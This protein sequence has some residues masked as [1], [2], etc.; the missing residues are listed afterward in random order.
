MFDSIQE[1]LSNEKKGGSNR[2]RH[3][4][5]LQP[6][7][8]YTVRLI[9]NVKSPKDTFFHYHHHGWTSVATGQYVD[10]ICPTTWGENCPICTE[11]F[12]MYNKGTEADR[13]LARLI[14]R[15]DKHFVNVYVVDDPTNEENN[16]TVKVLRFG[17]RIKEKFDLAISGDDAD[18]FGTKVFDLSDKGCNFKVKVESSSEGNRK[19]TNYNNSRFT[20]PSAI[21]GMTPAKIK[22]VYDQCYELENLIE[23]P[24]V[25]ELKKMLEVHLFDAGTDFSPKE[26]APK[27]SVDEVVKDVASDNSDDDT[28]DDDSSDDTSAKIEDLL[29][30]LDGLDED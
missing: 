13:E 8:T 12:K 1:S 28:S 17:V 18:E 5:R 2:F 7:N 23:R 19:F 24:T 3:L 14:R 6:G 30:D 29:A 27:K 22:E 9:P 15:M 26:K 11:R 21:P 4:L 16:G 20:S 10:A 25:E